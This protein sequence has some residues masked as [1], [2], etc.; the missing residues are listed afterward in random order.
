[1]T[2]KAIIA[3]MRQI[4]ESRTFHHTKTVTKRQVVEYENTMVVRGGHKLKGA[5]RTS[6]QVMEA[7]EQEEWGGLESRR[8]SPAGR[9]RRAL[10]RAMDV[11][12]GIRR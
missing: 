11:H 4:R 7:Y 12:A 5:Y 3:R 10:V 9:G 8:Q 1:M 6:L 2:E